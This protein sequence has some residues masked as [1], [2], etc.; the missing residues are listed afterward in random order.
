M[1]PCPYVRNVLV[2]MRL[3]TCIEDRIPL[4]KSFNR[5]IASFHLHRGPFGLRGVHEPFNSRSGIS[6]VG[7]REAKKCT[8]PSRVSA[9]S[10]IFTAQISEGWP[11]WAVLSGAGAI[12]QAGFTSFPRISMTD[13]MFIPWIGDRDIWA[14]SAGIASHRDR[15][16]D[17][18]PTAWHCSWPLASSLRGHSFRLHRLFHRLSV[19]PAPGCSALPPRVGCER[20]SPSFTEYILTSFEGCSELLQALQIG[21]A[22]CRLQI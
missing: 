20:V 19:P 16:P 8:S 22:R 6:V 1:F 2:K 14:V 13:Y 5:K 12:A 9:L 3:S 10:A 15:P 11:I 17:I 7:W 21:A 4:S 18:C